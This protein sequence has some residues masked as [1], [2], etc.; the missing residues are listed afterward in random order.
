MEIKN[1]VMGLLR[2]IKEGFIPGFLVIL[3]IVGTITVLNFMVTGIG[4]FLNPFTSFMVRLIPLLNKEA[5]QG[6]NKFVLPIVTILGISVVGHLVRKIPIARKLHMVWERIIA[7]IPIAN[8]IHRCI[9]D[10]LRAVFG[11]TRMFKRAVGVDQWDS[12][13]LAIGFVT[14]EGVKLIEDSEE[15]Y[16][17]V[18]EPSVPNPTGGWLVMAPKKFEEVN[19]HKS[20]V[21][22]LNMSVEEA[23]KMVMSAGAAVPE[24]LKKNVP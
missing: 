5:L 22:K 1:K 23:M 2:L 7:K 13:I 20:K 3:P 9:S 4:K 10:I 24:R 19:V 11:Q 21:K 18:Y 17:N 14:E 6:F 16:T 12:G 15:E 8:I